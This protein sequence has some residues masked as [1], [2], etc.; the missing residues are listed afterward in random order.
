MSFFSRPDLSDLQFKQLADSELHLSGTTYFIK[1]DGLQIADGSGNTIPIVG[2]GAT[3]GFV[4][5]YYDGSITLQA[6]SASGGTTIFDTHRPTTRSGVPV[7][8]VSGACTINNFLEGYFFPAVPPSSSLSVASGGNDREFGD[9]T[10]GNLCYDATRNT[11]QLCSAGVDTNADGSYDCF[12][13][14]TPITGSCNGI[15]AY[16]F[17]GTC[18]AP[19]TSG[20]SQ[21]S[22]SY[23]M[24]VSTTAS[25]VSCSSAGIT[26]RNKKFYFLSSTLYAAV[27]ALTLQG[28]ANGLI[29]AQA[30]LSTSKSANLSLTFSNEFFYYMY[31]TT[32]GTPSFT[33]NGLPNNAWGNAGTG[34]L[35]KIA[36][37]NSNTYLNEYYVA[38]SD[39][40]ITGTFTIAIT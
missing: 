11:N 10:Y 7:V 33:V 37:T 38:R 19:A 4:L 5:T 40:R 23:G 35:F 6:S 24:C 9:S 25:E 8:N 29:G 2:T 28:I 32:F 20:A 31:P 21:N 13:I 16:S 34:T 12:P 14:T 3:D 1:T 17:P 39:S 18:A 36:Y 22:A 27:D 15:Y 26:W 30:V